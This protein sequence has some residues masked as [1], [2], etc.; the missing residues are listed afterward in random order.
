MIRE[1]AD[2]IRLSAEAE[3]LEF[4]LVLPDSARLTAD[5]DQM[6]QL[7][8]NLL[9]NGAQASPPEGALRIHLEVQ[10]DEILLEVE[11]AG[12]GIAEEDRE[13]VFEPFYS[14]K[15]GGL[16]MGLALCLQ[17]V[18]AHGGTLSLVNAKPTGSLFVVTLPVTQGSSAPSESSNV[19]DGRDSLDFLLDDE[20]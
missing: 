6:R 4:D 12:E 3:D 13:R 11:D 2:V 16:G 15:R 8:W 18:T 9:R 20:G 7:L 19:F 10:D 5:P 1:V 17:V 14:T